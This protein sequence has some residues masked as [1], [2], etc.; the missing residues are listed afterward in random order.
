MIGLSCVHLGPHQW[1]QEVG[2]LN[3]LG[4]GQVIILY[5]VILMGVELSGSFRNSPL[6]CRLSGL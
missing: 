6:G 5:A 3:W 4:L 2:I 1:C